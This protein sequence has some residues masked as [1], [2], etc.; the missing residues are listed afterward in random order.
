MSALAQLGAAPAARAARAPTTREQSYLGAVEILF[1]EGEKAARDAQYAEAM[2]RLAAKYPGDHEAA[3]FYALAK[4]ATMQRGIEGIAAEDGHRHAL[5]GSEAQREVAAILQKVLKANP[6]HPGAAHYLIHVWDDPEHA[7]LALPIARTYARIAPAASH[8]RHMPSHVFFHLG[9]WDAASASDQ[10]AWEASVALAAK[11]G[12]AVVDAEL[13]QPVVAA[14]RL[15]SAGTVRRRRQDDSARSSR[16]QADREIPILM[17]IAASMRAR[18]VVDTARWERVRGRVQFDNHDEL[19]AIALGRGAGRRYGDGR[20]G[21]AGAG[22]ARGRGAHRRSPTDRRHP[23]ARDR[24]DAPA[25][26]G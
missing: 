26:R 23:R 11:Q 19:F 4:L 25:R 13:P 14:V 16:S 3:T 6:E 5:A 7:S 15:S 20:D 1:G 10:S 21:P 17:G 24:R 22:A 9:L 12:A 18:A 8:A 2:A